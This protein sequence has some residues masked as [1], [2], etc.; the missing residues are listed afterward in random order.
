MQPTTPGFCTGKISIILRLEGLLV[1]TLA[2]YIYNTLPDKS[3]KLFAYCF[4]VPDISFLGYII[5]KRT[6]AVSYNIMHSYILPLSV[7]LISYQLPCHLMQA[8]SIIWIAHIGFDR[9]LGY[10]LKYADGFSYTHLGLIGKLK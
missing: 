4:F 6:G 1:L 2:C 3:W 5:G 8:I 9:A 7:L 10:G